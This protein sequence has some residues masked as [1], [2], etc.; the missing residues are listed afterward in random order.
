MVVIQLWRGQTGSRLAEEKM[1]YIEDASIGND[2]DKTLL[3][4]MLAVVA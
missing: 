4:M 1:I 2:G 3:F